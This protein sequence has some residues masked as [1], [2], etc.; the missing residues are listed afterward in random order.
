MKLHPFVSTVCFAALAVSLSAAPP[1]KL[2]V[3]A[4]EH[5]AIV[6]NALA[7]RMLHDG[8]LEAFIHKAQPQDNISVRN[9][10]FAADEINLHVRSDEVP[11]P[12]D[13][14]K[15]MQADVVLAFW[16]F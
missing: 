9:L 14:L 4:G 5:V 3:Q 8:T 13:W 10:G 6:G 1:A 11:P 15:K 16:G 7:D 12:E 2:T